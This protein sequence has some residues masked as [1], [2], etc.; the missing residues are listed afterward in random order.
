MPRLAVGGTD[1]Q[2]GGYH[3]DAVL[4]SPG[5]IHSE[6]RVIQ[7]IH[8]SDYQ[9]PMDE[10]D[11]FEVCPKLGMSDFSANMI[12]ANITPVAQALSCKLPAAA[13]QCHGKFDTSERSKYSELTNG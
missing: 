9:L 8:K 11:Q 5:R 6:L 4:N 12:A 7:L 3:K 2:V 1:L 13:G 10:L